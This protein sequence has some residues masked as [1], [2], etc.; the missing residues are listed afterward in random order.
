[1]EVLNLSIKG[2]YVSM[3]GVQNFTPPTNNTKG[4]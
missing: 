3:E 2:E 1:M 4:F